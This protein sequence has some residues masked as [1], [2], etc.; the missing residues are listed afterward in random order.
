MEVFEHG[1][2]YEFFPDRTSMYKENLNFWKMCPSG[3]QPWE[4]EVSR[5]FQFK[6]NTGQLVANINEWVID[7]LWCEEINYGK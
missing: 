1:K 6:G 3:R 4:H 5:K 7:R 2:F